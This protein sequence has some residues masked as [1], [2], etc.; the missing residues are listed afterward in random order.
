[1]NL[2]EIK[3]ILKDNSITLDIKIGSLSDGNSIGLYAT[4]GQPA[5]LYFDNQKLER[6]GLQVYI[7]HESYEQG[8]TIIRQIYDILNKQVGFSPQQSPFY[9]G[10]NE[11]NY[12][13]FSVNY[14]LKIE[15]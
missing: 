10:R 14:I 12:A 3:Q 2:Q 5:V 15:N 1:M 11:K 9:V 4:A 8:Y 13:E 7:R 6:P